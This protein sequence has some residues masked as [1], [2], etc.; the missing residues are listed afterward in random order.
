MIR[1]TEMSKSYVDQLIKPSDLRERERDFTND[2]VI[3]VSIFEEKKKSM[4][5]IRMKSPLTRVAMV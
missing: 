1:S 2:K 4:I 5:D 3:M